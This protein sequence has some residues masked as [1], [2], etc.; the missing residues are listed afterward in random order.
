V[1][2]DIRE[3]IHAGYNPPKASK[4]LFRSNHDDASGGAEM[5]RV[6]SCGGV[7]LAAASKL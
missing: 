7:T 6:D 1:A 3:P 2:G 5:C 4:N